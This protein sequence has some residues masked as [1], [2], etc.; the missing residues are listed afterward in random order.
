MAEFP[1]DLVG[2]DDAKT[3]FGRRS[4]EHDEKTVA[5]AKNDAL[6]LKVKGEETD[7]W[8]VV[9][10]S[11]TSAR[12]QKRKS[13]SRQLEDDVWSLLYRL[14]F[15]ELNNDRLLTFKGCPFDVFAKDEN[16]VLVVECTHAEEEKQESLKSLIDKIKVNA[17]D[18]IQAVHTHYGKE[19]KLKVKFAIATRNVDLREADR[20]DAKN[21]GIAL[22]SEQ[23]IEYY[24]KLLGYVK[25]A[26]RFQ[27]L[28]HYLAGEDVEGLGLEVS[29][30][31]GEMG[32]TTFYNFLISPYDLMKIAYVSHKS[33]DLDTY[34]RMV[35]PT[36]LK[37]IAAYIDDGGQF[38][39]NIVINFKAKKPLEFNKDENFEG[40]ALGTL[41]L[42]G[43]YGAAWIID[44]QHRLYGFSFAEK[45]R[46]H[47]VPVLAYENM[48]VSNE[49]QLFIDINSKQVKVS[50][51]LLNELYSNLNHS[52]DDP[53]KQFESLF[54]RVAV[55][56]NTIAKSP[57]KDRVQL[58]EKNKDRFRCLSLT[59]LADGIKENRF[60]GTMTLRSP[61][62]AVHQPGSLCALSGTYAETA[63]RA[64]DV[65][66]GYF[67]LFAKGVPENWALG[68]DKKGGFLCTNNGLRALMR[69]L[70][71]LIAFVEQNQQ[72]QAQSLDADDLLGRVAPL[73]Q[74]LVDFFK[75]ADPIQVKAFRN[76]QALAGVKENCLSMMGI[77]HETISEFTNKDLEDYLKNRDEKGTQEAG[78]LIN[79][80]NKILYDDIIARLKTKFGNDD[81][82]WWNG[83]PN[84]IRQEC[85]KRQN[86]A[87]GEKEAWQYLSLGT[88][89]QIVSDNW[90]IFQNDYALGDKKRGKKDAAVSWIH[91][92]SKARQTTAHP[93]KGLLPKTEVDWV[94]ET[95]I[96]I[97]VHIVKEKALEAV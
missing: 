47:M 59:S 84:S 96:K 46:K 6:S 28:A 57:I 31:R 90:D 77:I 39:T 37:S 24:G 44:G 60:L 53:V 49:M 86:D 88:Y 52:S 13:S 54:S 83:V 5:A 4:K 8:Q 29:A 64:A 42:P 89:K 35:K 91:G 51:N 18:V 75:N 16:T 25:G 40:S 33:A 11:K 66:A 81:K 55:N 21:A 12:M 45:G 78:Q 72:V 94:K 97:K 32:G 20:K 71:E 63:E 41:K 74:P 68:D 17:Q 80:I 50:R 85:L 92:L 15:S 34:Q 2:G 95:Y 58:A 10:S 82:W 93:E 19:S 3:V 7:G 22:I 69:L 76:R 73:T 27:F 38:P 87:K 23:D 65:L 9:R 70:K 48:A 67:S 61:D 1:K 30:M 79:E 36:R 56:L 26:A 62:Q 14:G 43:F